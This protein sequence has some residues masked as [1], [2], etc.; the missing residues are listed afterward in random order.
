[1]KPVGIIANPA[2]GRDI[3]RLVSS[4]DAA[5]ISDKVSILVRMARALNALGIERAVFMPDPNGI[6]L[7]VAEGLRGELTATSIETLALDRP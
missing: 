7:Q 2:S 5:P 4:A 1:M 6:A 3:R